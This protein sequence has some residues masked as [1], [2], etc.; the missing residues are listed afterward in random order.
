MDDHISPEKP[1]D[2]GPPAAARSWDDGP[3]DAG[4]ASVA[5]CPPRGEPGV[6]GREGRCPR[7]D[8]G[9]DPEC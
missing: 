5:G 8:A 2:R 1:P 3:V 9:M 6:G 4:R 7:Q